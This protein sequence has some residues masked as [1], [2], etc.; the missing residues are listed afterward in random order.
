MCTGKTENDRTCTVRVTPG[1][2]VR[3]TFQALRVY[4]VKTRKQRTV[5][6]RARLFGPPV[7]IAIDNII[8]VEKKKKTKKGKNKQTNRVH[9]TN[10]MLR[11]K[12]PS[13]RSYRPYN[14]DRSNRIVNF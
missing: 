1:V 13:D 3:Y 9:H 14:G 7:L 4:A 2:R 10:E 12:R 6:Q 8:L 5:V 11:F